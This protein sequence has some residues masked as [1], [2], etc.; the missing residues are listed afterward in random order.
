MSGQTSGGSLPESQRWNCAVLGWQ[1]LRARLPALW[2]MCAPQ[3]QEQG[4]CTLHLACA[5]PSVSH[6]AGRAKPVWE[7]PQE[8]LSLRLPC[9]RINTGVGRGR[10]L[11]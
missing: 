7:K 3:G 11:R 6:R 1:S 4:L 2:R 9:S 8:T 10:G 5:H